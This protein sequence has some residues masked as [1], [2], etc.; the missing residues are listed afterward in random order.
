MFSCKLL[1][2]KKKNQ[3]F[4]SS[5]P[6]PVTIYSQAKWSYWMSVEN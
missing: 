6:D 2:I 3:G 1:F 5:V 4:T